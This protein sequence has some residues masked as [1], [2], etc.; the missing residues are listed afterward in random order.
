MAT[1]ITN[2][3]TYDQAYYYADLKGL[4][5]LSEE[6]RRSLVTR[7]LTADN[8][9]QIKQHLMGS[10]LHFAKHYAIE[11]CPTSRYHR[12]LPDLIGIAN[13]TVVEVLSRTDLTQVNH[14]TSY[15]AAYLR[16]RLKEAALSATCRALQEQGV[17]VTIRALAQA[18][19]VGLNRAQQFLRQ[20]RDQFPAGPTSKAS[21]HEQRLAHVAGVYAEHLAQGKPITSSKTLARAAHVRIETALEFL[22]I[23]RSKSK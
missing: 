15:L 20:H 17:P 23:E 6:D 14:L 5:R 1:T 4:P 22:R 8:P 2:Y 21:R 18:A 13:L 10:Y 12:D 7:L 3:T 16:G 9:A 11:L 19:G